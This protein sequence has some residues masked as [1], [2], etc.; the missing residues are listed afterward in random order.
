MSDTTLRALV[1]L[2][3]FGA[4]LFAADVALQWMRSTRNKKRAVNKRLDMIAHG[5]DQATIAAKLRRD[6]LAGAIDL[7]G[8]LSGPGKRLEKV[9]RT[10]GLPFS[11]VQIAAW[12][13]MAAFGIF[14]VVL[15]VAVA[16]GVGVT[17]GVVVMI[18]TFAGVVGVALPLLIF[19]RA[20]DRRHKKLMEQFPVALD[21]FVRGLRAGH[22]VASA[23]DL[24]TREMSDPIGSEFG[25]AA[26]E[27]TYGAD[28][29]DALHNMAERCDLD[30]MRMFVVSLAIQNETGGNLAE[31]LENL[32]KVIRE[33]ASM[34]MMVRA[35]SS[36]G[37]MTGMILTALPLMAFAA[38][39]VLNPAFYLDVAGDPAFLTGFAAL[40]ALYF[41]GFF[42]IRRMVDLKV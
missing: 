21:I 42:T 34:A 4:T 20:A 29:R 14:L 15:A 18:A 6:S 9:L 33:R 12:M 1:L 41:I 27:V 5:A 13:A 7:P 30:D 3:V 40:I 17:L 10:S 31:I 2:L 39:F 36:E 11:P 32:S 19:A 22:P 16:T 25:L 23:L 38:L 8:V 28:L 26:D 35:L 24:L 37:R